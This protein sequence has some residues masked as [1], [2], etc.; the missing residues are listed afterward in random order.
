MLL[1]QVIITVGLTACFANLVLNLLALKTPRRTATLPSPAPRL[2]VMI[3]ARNEAANIRACLESLQ[4]QDYPDFEILVLDDNSSDATGDIVAGMA[5]ADPRIRLYRGAPLPDDWAGKPYACHQ[6]SQQATGE[7]FLFVDADTTHE[8][9]MLR[10]VLELAMKHGTALLSGFPRQL[11]TSLPQKIALPMMYYVVLSWAPLWWL[12]RAR[13]PQPSL[14]IGQ[15]MLF[16]R[17]AYLQIGGHEA[18]KARII[19]DVWLGVEITRSGGRHLAVNLAPVVSC[20]MYRD[21]GAMWEGFLKWCY[22]VACLSAAGL[23]ALIVAG[24]FMFLGPFFWLWQTAVSLPAMATWEWYVVAQ[25]GII[26][27]ARVLL[28]LRFREPLAPAITQPLG[29]AYLVAATVTAS[30]RQMVGA[31]VRWKN[32]EYGRE[33]VVR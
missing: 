31:G 17:D 3:P 5:A 33:S 19:E 6:L 24:L 14:A 20:L 21:L 15:F 29:M 22:S 16:P 1:Y 25:V 2:S 10:S 26:Y 28:D 4:R 23:G 7:W 8:P 12:H 30:L 13:T 9:H 11:A 18:V 32:R 27:A